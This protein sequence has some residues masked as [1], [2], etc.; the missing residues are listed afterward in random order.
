[1]DEI[2]L[3]WQKKW[4][5]GGIFNPSPSSMPKFYLT[6]A[7]PYPNSPQHIG[8]ART[9][10]TTDI[11]A[12]YK[13]M[14]GFNVLFPMGFHVTG[15]P[16]LAMAK[17][18]AQ[19]DPDILGVFDKIYGIPA[20]T[21]A[22]LTDPISLVMHFSN[23]IELG[24]KE[25]GFSIDWRRK[26][27]S[28][29]PAFNRFIE[30]QFRMLEKKGYIKKGSH[31]VPWCPADNNSV[32]AHDTRGDVDPTLEEVTLVKFAYG[33]GF[34]LASTYRPETV[35]GVTN[36]WAHPDAKY[37]KVSFAGS[38]YYI[39]TNQVEY[40]SN[41]FEGLKVIEEIGFDRLSRSK[42]TNLATGEKVP[43]ISATFVDPAHGTG[44]V[45]SVPAHAPY[46]YLALR[47][48]NLPEITMKNVISLAG[49]GEF[50]A[51]EIV[52]QM[53]VK[54]QN[55]PRAEEAT[56]EIYRKEAHE[57]IMAVGKF[58]GMK[59]SIAK[60]EVKKELLEQGFALKFHEI[61]NSPVF[62]RCG[63]RIVVKNVTGQWFIDYG[64][65]EWKKLAHECL[66]SMSILPEKSRA[67]LNYTLDWLQKKACSRAQGLGTKLPF[68]TAQIIESLS[69][70]TIYMAFYTIAH[71]VKAMPVE[72]AND[73]FFDYAF[74][75]VK[76]A[77]GQV[78]AEMESAR[79]EFLYWYPLDSRH[80]GADLIYNHLAFF[81]FNHVAIFP[82]SGWPKQIVANGFVTMDGK[83]MSK[84]MGNIL[85]LRKAIGQYGADVVRFSVVNG[86]ELKEDSDFSQTAANGVAA[87]L[88]QLTALLDMA[89]AETPG[90][91]GEGSLIQRWLMSR[92]HERVA[93]AP[94]LYDSLS[95]RELGQ[96]FFFNTSNDL[97]WYMK[98]CPK[99]RLRGFFSLWVPAIA[100]IMPHFAEECWQKLGGKGFVS[101]AAFPEA[102][103][104][105]IDKSLEAMEEL[106]AQ[107][108]G[109]IE[110]I[111]GILK[112]PGKPKGIT[113]FA[114][115]EW[116]YVL[117]AIVAR[118]RNPSLAIKAAMADPALRSHGNEVPKLV[119]SYM[120]N[121]G[122]LDKSLPRASEVEALKDAC[123]FYSR[124]FGCPVS[125]VPEEEAGKEQAQKARNAMPG[126]CAILVSA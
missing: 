57:G 125:L 100:P 56:K 61:A 106:V 68:D 10:T 54:D 51:K 47:D 36:I 93:N 112:I 124:E 41:Q 73:E 95:L 49:F 3:T 9:Y 34:L 115:S 6:A 99:P 22:K 98:R 11:Y 5:D 26:F 27:Y 94:A 1:M 25:I 86:A 83:K 12:R 2:A 84:S 18:I 63:A 92:L 53:G 46:D 23:E 55:D 52:E 48:A 62:C 88:R 60:D 90:D 32:S 120:K 17:R 72:K 21:A 78:S 85:P 58:K 118:E 38:T 103:K 104:A 24:M 7:F 8:H 35:Y 71:I 108:K 110:Q 29:D 122:G 42:A 75:G 74:F 45:M 16:I 28:N 121:I 50:P 105:R 119:A 111:L 107:S 82:K 19:K 117:K 13:R 33:D 40:F 43:I 116:K 65:P 79:K 39:S 126:K 37:A 67:D 109:D 20:D 15:T 77:G 91:S 59:V 76:P 114:A 14:K 87:R 96:E 69:D 80:S 70:S 64:D 81:I 66:D 30:W 97:S 31:P 123:D 102:E 4:A 89:C 101:L 113:L 44:I